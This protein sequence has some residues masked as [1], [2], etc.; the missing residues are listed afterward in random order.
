MLVHGQAAFADRGTGR[1]GPVR[2]HSWL[3]LPSG[4]VWEPVTCETWTA[5]EWQEAA[6]PEWCVK[7]TAA[8]GWL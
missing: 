7:Y 3:E 8:S 6:A 2:E 4:A 5:A 1:S